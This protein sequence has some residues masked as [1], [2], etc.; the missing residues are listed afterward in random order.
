M[1]TSAKH[2]KHAGNS[3]T[4]AGVLNDGFRKLVFPEPLESNYR[5]FNAQR[6]AEMIRR[7]MPWVTPFWLVA[8]GLLAVGF[9]DVAGTWIHNAMLPVGVA[10]G[11]LWL[12]MFTR[13]LERDVHLHVGL[14]LVLAQ[15]ATLRT[16]FLLG[17]DP[18]AL[19]VIL[20]SIYLLV[21]LFTLSRLPLSSAL[22]CA[23]L[24]GVLA[25]LAASAEHLAIDWMQ[26]L[27][28]YGNTLM[29]GAVIGYVLEHRERTAWLT[30]QQ[31]DTE[32][33]E[34]SELRASAD[35]ASRRQQRLSDYLQCISGN[36]TPTEIAGRTLAFLIEHTGA[37][38]G[39]I[40]VSSGSRMRRAAARGLDGETRLPEDLGRGETLIGQAAENRRR[41]RLLHLP[42]DYCAIRTATGATRPAEVLIEPV[43]SNGRTLAVIELGSLHHFSDESVE[44]VDHLAPTVAGALVAAMAR[45]QLA[46]VDFDEFA[47]PDAPATP[48]FML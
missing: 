31:R 32:M 34:L 43:H 21:I 29:L 8:A 19:Y 5:E 44:L 6:S 4:I 18:F 33:R 7:I 37:Q 45:D 38:V 39:A 9:S 3:T 41:M 1:N 25:L 35:A 26:L 16:V 30:A 10:I 20:Q 12:T 14:A 22:L 42:D 13:W 47:A 24:P 11:W 28:F 40:F 36:P 23:L 15:F 2:G 46:D 48:G 27:Q 17:D